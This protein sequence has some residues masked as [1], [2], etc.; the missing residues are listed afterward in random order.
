MN[1]I[2]FNTNSQYKITKYFLHNFNFNLY[3]NSILSLFDLREESY[4]K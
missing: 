4:K 2:Y 3:E 1:K